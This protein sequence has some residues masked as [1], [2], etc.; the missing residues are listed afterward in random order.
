MVKPRCPSRGVALLG[1]SVLPALFYLL[2]FSFEVGPALDTP[3]PDID[4]FR[5][6]RDAAQSQQLCRQARGLGGFLALQGCES[7]V[8]IGF[9][10]D[11]WNEF[12]V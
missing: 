3:G 9:V 7:G 11:L 12:G 5:R 1:P 8:V 10:C 4:P 2:I 6:G